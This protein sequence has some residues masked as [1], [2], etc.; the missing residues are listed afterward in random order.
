M[1]LPMPFLR[2][3]PRARADFV[4]PGMSVPAS[5]TPR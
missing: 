5:V 3:M 4:M 2:R 1:V